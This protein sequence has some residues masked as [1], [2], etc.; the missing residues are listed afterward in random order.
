MFR[1][2]SDFPD[3]RDDRTDYSSPDDFFGDEDATSQTMGLRAVGGRLAQVESQ[4]ASQFTSLAT[5][6]QIAQ[7]QVE[8][9]RGEARH[10]TE[11]N[12]ARVI[13]LLDQE[14]AERLAEP[15]A[16]ELD[17]RLGTIETQIAEITEM[18]QQCLAGQ[19]AL[20]DLI[21]EMAVAPTPETQPAKKA[22]AARLARTGKGRLA[23]A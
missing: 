19:N 3:V 1:R 20:V 2:A 9:A 10:E 16:A 21:A 14:R 11:R 4:I 5:Y 12:T 17:E 8:L 23:L 6:S 22:A 13:A 15:S 7:A 18:V